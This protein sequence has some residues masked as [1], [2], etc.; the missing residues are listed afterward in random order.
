MRRLILSLLILLISAT[1]LQAQDLTQDITSEQTQLSFSLPEGWTTTYTPNGGTFLTFNGDDIELDLYTP[2]SLIYSRLDDIEKPNDLLAEFITL[3]EWEPGDFETEE[4]N[5]RVLTIASY[6]VDDFEGILV[7]IP[8]DDSQFAILDTYQWDIDSDSDLVLAI[9][10]T[11]ESIPTPLTIDDYDGDWQGVIAQLEDADLIGSDGSL[12]FEEDRA[13]FE[14]GGAFFTPLASNSPQT[15]FVM[16]GTLT[17][18]ASSEFTTQEELETCNLLARIQLN[19]NDVAEDYLEVGI[20]N[21]GAVFYYTAIGTDVTNYAEFR[22]IDL[23]EPFHVL[24]IADGDLLTLFL[25]GEQVGGQLPIDEFPGI[26]GIVLRGQDVNTSCVGENIW[27][28]RIPRAQTGACRVVANSAVNKRVDAGTSF[29]IGGQLVPDVPEDVIAQVTDQ[30]GFVW[31]QLADENWVRSD[32]VN[33]LGD[34]SE[35]PVI[36]ADA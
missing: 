31:W 15:N 35:I 23:E 2:Y 8:L 1:V 26:F 4:V 13:F 24:F 32:V 34:C 36:E 19:A 3:N 9:A 21:S 16:A 25:D 7:A 10:S 12:V 33:L 27:V 29:D 17:F 11:V 30:D 14:G 6:V 20:D 22:R 28:Y 5:G 18:T